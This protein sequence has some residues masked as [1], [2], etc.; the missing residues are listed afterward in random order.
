[1]LD[2]VRAS[3]EEETPV[4][5]AV[6]G[7]IDRANGRR[8]SGWAWNRL[9]PDHHLEIEIRIDDQ[10][11]AM[12]LADRRR[13][14]LARAG[15]GE[16]DHAFEAT[17]EDVLPED[18]GA[19]VSAFARVGASA[20]PLVNRTV[21]PAQPQLQAPER[22]PIGDAQAAPPPELRRWLDD[23]GTVQ[24]SFEAALKVAAQEIHEAV[25]NCQTAVGATAANPPAT[26]ELERQLDDLKTAQ[27][28][29]A[30]Q[31]SNIEVFQAR[32]DARLALLDHTEDDDNE[33]RGDR[34]L[35][36]VVLTC[37]V[38][39]TVSLLLGLWSVLH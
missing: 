33:T 23:L 35:R 10:P 38:I 24:K 13:N 20:V 14:D 34:S 6:V 8:I 25:R 1:M 21:T 5:E 37:S 22:A 29:I 4:V 16:G 30:R 11:I 32:L 18:A 12:V 3:T 39:S 2:P 9:R 27:E 15:I 19:R 36:F 26:A 28:G 17:L 31:L 7:Y